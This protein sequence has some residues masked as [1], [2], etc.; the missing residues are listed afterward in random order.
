MNPRIAALAVWPLLPVIAAQGLVL[1][2]RVPRLPDAAGPREGLI[3]AKTEKPLRLLVFGDSTVA[4]IGA[5]THETALAGQTAIHLH[6]RSG[7]AIAWRAVGC[8]GATAETA[9]QKLIPELKDAQADILVISLGVNDTIKLHSPERWRRNLARLLGAV[10]E[11]L[12]PVP[13]VLSGIPP[14]EHFPAL[15][16]P[17]RFAFSRRAAAL[18]Q[19]GAALLATWPDALHVLF[20]GSPNVSGFFAADGFHPGPKGYDL[21][22]AALAEQAARLIGKPQASA[23]DSKVCCYQ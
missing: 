20:Q 12:G 16:Q 2:R 13:I 9:Y 8:S 11:A 3:G 6:R 10:R 23:A 15:P 17:L 5:K 4:G 21:I 14:I 1:R 7:C 19:A 22:G 18:D